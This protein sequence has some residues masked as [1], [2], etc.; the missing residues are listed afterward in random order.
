MRGTQT[1]VLKNV[2]IDLTLWTLPF[3]GEKENKQT[4]NM[5]EIN[6]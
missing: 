4:I 1:T 3:S 6:M 2:N 5:Y